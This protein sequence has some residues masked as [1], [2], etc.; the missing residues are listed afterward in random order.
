MEHHISLC[1]RFYIFLCSACNFW[2]QQ[3]ATSKRLVLQDVSGWVNQWILPL[4]SL[5]VWNE[6]YIPKSLLSYFKK[7]CCMMLLFPSDAEQ[8]MR[9]LESKANQKRSVHR[10]VQP[11]FLIIVFPQVFV[12]Q[13]RKTQT[14][15]WIG[16]TSSEGQ[17]NVRKSDVAVGVSQTLLSHSSSRQQGPSDALLEQ[18]HYC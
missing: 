6:V 2:Q 8:E 15:H 11:M 3:Q 1:T 7:T 16:Q 5:T 13:M 17:S 18:K 4:K 10:A 12:K 14:G 9:L